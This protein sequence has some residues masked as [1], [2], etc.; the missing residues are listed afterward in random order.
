MCP[1]LGKC[2]KESFCPYYHNNNDQRK[3]PHT[4]GT[5]TFKFVPKN[6]ILTN[7]F[8]NIKKNNID[9]FQIRKE[10]NQDKTTLI[11]VPTPDNIL[12]TNISKEKRQSEQ[13]GDSYCKEI[14]KNLEK[15][16]AKPKRGSLIL[17]N[18]NVQEM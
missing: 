15:S 5:N 2:S 3:V 17:S 16:L 14:M 7:T 10:S 1:N 4:V 11:L 9:T 13:L 12:I 6:R 8:K 18:T